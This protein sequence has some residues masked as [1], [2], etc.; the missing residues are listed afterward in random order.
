MC[1]AIGTRDVATG[2]IMIR[3]LWFGRPKIPAFPFLSH[4]NI[5][6]TRLVLVA[7]SHARR[8]CI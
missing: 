3:R 6:A 7:R 1:D 5:N 4:G 2:P 8:H